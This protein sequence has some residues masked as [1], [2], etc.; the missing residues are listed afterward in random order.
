MQLSH[1]NDYIT[2]PKDTGYK[3]LHL[4]VQP[5][6]NSKRTIEI[7]LRSVEEHNWATLVE[8]TDLLYHT[9]LK[10]TGTGHELS[11]FHKLLSIG[12]TRLDV[13]QKKKLIRIAKKIQLL[14]QN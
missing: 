8:I 13:E 10:E 6:E 11:E 4:I 5:S 9:K 3:S 2:T 12:T 1:F 14:F 7:Q